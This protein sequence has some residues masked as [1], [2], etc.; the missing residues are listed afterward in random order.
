MTINSKFEIKSVLFFHRNST[1]HPISV[2]FV[3]M[4]RAF[5]GRPRRGGREVRRE[6]WSARTAQKDMDSMVISG[7]NR[8]RYGIVPYVGPYILWVY[9]LRNL[10]LKFR[11]FFWG[12]GTSNQ[13]DPEDLPLMDTRPWGYRTAPFCGA[14]EIA[15]V[16]ITPMTMVDDAYNYI[17]N[18]LHKRTFN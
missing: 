14:H 7:T 8:W 16:M 17:V 13:S 9:S 15:K 11:P 3:P 10:G 1:T 5:A 2:Y 4:D 12:I 6:G 18:R